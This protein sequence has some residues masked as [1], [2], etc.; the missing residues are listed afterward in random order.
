MP[1]GTK[2]DRLYRKLRDRGYSAGSAARIAQKVTGLSLATG[3]KPKKFCYSCRKWDCQH[4]A[5]PVK[6]AAK[7]NGVTDALI[8]SLKVQIAALDDAADP[9]GVVNGLTVWKVDGDEAKIEHDMDFVEAGN[10]F[11]WQF[12]PKD[13][14]WV[15]EDLESHDWPFN[16]LHE[17]VEVHLMQGGMEYDA[18]HK[19]ANRHER[20]WRIETAMNALADSMLCSEC[21][22]TGCDHVCQG[23]AKFAVEKYAKRRQD[24]QQSILPKDEG[25][26]GKH[27][28]TIGGHAGPDGKHVGGV[29]VEVE[30]GT[31][32]KG[33]EK[34]I[35]K[36][37][38]D[39]LGEKK[40]NGDLLS[41]VESQGEYKRQRQ[42][43]EVPGENFLQPTPQGRAAPVEAPIEKQ[44][45]LLGTEPPPV[46]PATAPL[47]GQQE[48]PLESPAEIPAAPPQ[49]SR[50]EQEAAYTKELED[51]YQLEGTAPKTETD[52]AKAKREGRNAKAREKRQAAIAHKQQLTKELIGTLTGYGV[53]QDEL[54]TRADAIEVQY[55]DAKEYN[56][57]FAALQAAAKMSPSR[58]A[59]IENAK[60]ATEA[61]R[62]GLKR[63]DTSKRGD[64]S[65]NIDDTMIESWA[66]EY[67][68]LGIKPD[69]NGSDILDILDK[70]PIE[71]PS[72][73]DMLREAAQDIEA[74]LF[75][76]NE[77]FAADKIN[78]MFADADAALTEEI[79]MP[80]VEEEL[81]W[82]ETRAEE[83]AQSGETGDYQGQ[84]PR[85][86]LEEEGREFEEP[87]AKAAAQK[88]QEESAAPEGKTPESE[89]ERITRRQKELM[90]QPSETVAE[91]L[92][93]PTAPKAPKPLPKQEV[94]D[95]GN[96]HLAALQ[97]LAD[98]GITNATP[99][100][101]EKRIEQMKA[102]GGAKKERKAG[103]RT[104]SPEEVEHRAKTKREEI[105][106]REQ[107]RRKTNAEKERV[108]TE[109][110]AK[111]KAAIKKIP[112]DAKA[113]TKQWM[114]DTHAKVA[115]SD[116]ELAKAI[117]GWLASLADAASP[118]WDIRNVAAGIRRH[119][120]ATMASNPNMRNPSKA[121][122][123]G[124]LISG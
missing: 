123:G 106:F 12:I 87:E 76:V 55:A 10:G 6:Y 8:E 25:E 83:I 68:M 111:R 84:T 33:P 81:R 93:T 75:N 30:G 105:E 91:S 51:R 43:E 114:Q 121:L 70:G 15:D 28:I 95:R 50:G 52:A 113:K 98:E 69:A 39:P 101:L 97:S 37:P 79:E 88:P 26:S 116:P 77:D 78:E 53:T 42:V 20:A 112:A 109:E 45:N 100:I 99:E 34:M 29:H 115:E 122:P 82:D 63:K 14:I 80:S 61:D 48:L 18:A 64:A 27:W 54:E 41:G 56:R 110:I 24:K 120:A 16:V 13:E 102:E 19:I 104:L 2:V 47:P 124:R 103:Q 66:S 57:Q 38:D 49:P 5:A 31:I 67:P 21:G 96:L 17:A 4:V 72:H 119:R 23:V 74:E 92:T 59:Q 107:Q 71:I 118:F 32:I 1:T 7:D 22:E 86:I 58:R 65:A 36:S 117:E 90:D 108:R 44:G 94:R 73:D 40:P 89:S 46:N 60:T 3:R 35:G 11:R 85:H 9:L 62:V